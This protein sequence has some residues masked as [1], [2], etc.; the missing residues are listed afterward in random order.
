M[1]LRSDLIELT[2]RQERLLKIITFLLPLIFI[3]DAIALKISLPRWYYLLLCKED[4][5]LEN[6]TAIFYFCSFV[7][8]MSIAKHFLKKQHK[9]YSLLYF[10]L[11]L[12]FF[13]IAIEEISW[14]QR[15]FGINTATFFQERNYQHENNFHNFKE[16]PLHLAYMIVGF[17]GA[18]AKLFIPDK[19][20]KRYDSVIQLFCADYFL[21]FY[22]FTVSFLYLYYDYLSP[23]IVS[24]FGETYGWGKEHFIVGKDQEPA[25]FLLSC[26]FLL[27]VIIQ[28]YRQVVGSDLEASTQES[29]PY[30]VPTHLQPATGVAR[31]YRNSGPRLRNWARVSR[32]GRWTGGNL[33]RRSRGEVGGGR[34][35]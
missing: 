18:F 14:G 6:L 26:G 22:F 9:F 32:H 10:I 35:A 23:M 29:H 25:E 3:W 5:A 28:K 27:F 33:M 16:F 15:I 13:F 17:Y 1:R 12:G 34:N 11:S 30:W 31:Y 20:K 21:F 2:R 4:G 19:T 7:L 24:L 8:A